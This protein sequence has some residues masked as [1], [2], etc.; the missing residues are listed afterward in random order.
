[1]MAVSSLVLVPQPARTPGIGVGLVAL[2]FGGA[3]LPIQAMHGP[4]SPDD[5]RW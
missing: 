3:T 4:D 2:L 5:P 1:M